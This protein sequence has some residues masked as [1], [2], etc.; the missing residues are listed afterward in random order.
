MPSN[1]SRVRDLANTQ[2]MWLFAKYLEKCGRLQNAAVWTRGKGQ[3]GE[4]KPL[5]LGRGILTGNWPR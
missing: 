2:Q 3:S 4:S 5:Q 1:V